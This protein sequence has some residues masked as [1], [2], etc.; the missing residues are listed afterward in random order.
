MV[1]QAAHTIS[2]TN[3]QNY[4]SGQPLRIVI[5]G[6]LKFMNGSKLSLPCGSYVIVKVGGAVQA[7]VGLSNSNFIEICGNVEWNSSQTLNGPACLPPSHPICAGA[8][9]PMELSYFSANTC[10]ANICLNWQTETERNCDH[11]EIQK[12]A[13][14]ISFYEINRVPSKAV[15]GYSYY[16]L[17]YEASDNAPVNGVSYYRLK[18]VDRDGS[19]FYSKTLS[20]QKDLKAGS[21]VIVYPSITKGEFSALIMRAGVSDAVILLRNAGGEIVYKEWKYMIDTNEPIHVVPD[22]PLANGVYYC[23]VLLDK[24]EYNLKVVISDVH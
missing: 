15:S 20:V 11:F 2:V 12:S 24:E 4:T 21:N 13:D 22:H 16:H 7:D 14:G 5:Y 19:Y 23:S 10:D 8:V 6:K 18:Q 9:L 1:I 17:Y 3:Q